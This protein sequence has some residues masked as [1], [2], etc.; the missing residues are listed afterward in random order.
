MKDYLGVEGALRD[1]GAARSPARR[2]FG[3]AMRAGA[4]LFVIS[5]AAV[6]AA[7]TAVPGPA[8]TLTSP[9]SLVSPR[10]PGAKAV[11]IDD[12][13]TSAR[14]DSAAWSADGKT[15][16]YTSDRGG[17]IN[18]WSRSVTG[19]VAHQL[20]NADMR[21]GGIAATPDGKSILFNADKG[22]RQVFDLYA[23]PMAGGDPVNL[24]ATDDVSETGAIPSPDGRFL[25][26]AQRVA[27][28]PSYDI[29]IFDMA[30]SKARQ[31][32]HEATDGIQWM[33]VAISRDSRHILAN[34]FDWSLTVGE[35]YI[36]DTKTGASTRLTPAGVY[37]R[38]GDISPDG[39][40]VSASLENKQGVRQAIVIDV[41]A[42]TTTQL[43]HSEWEETAGRF[44]PDGKSLVVTTNVDG[45]DTLALYDV[46]SRK[47][48]PLRVPAGVNSTAGYVTGLPS[49]SPD[50]RRLLFPHS[51]GSEPLD[52]WVYDLGTNEATRV[53]DLAGTFGARLP[54]TQIVHYS[55][56]DG[57]VVSALLWMPFNL[58]RD[59][60]A[61]AVVL[62]HGGPTGQVTDSFDR[63]AAALASRGYVVIAPNFRGSTG[64]GRAFL[65]ANRKDLGGGDLADV[66]AGADF[67]TRSGYVDPKRIG[68]TGGSYGGYM[69]LMA[70]SKMP[71]KWA[72]GVELFGI[73]NWRTMW[74]HGAPQNRRYQAGLIGDPATDAEVYDRVSPLTYLD[75]T[76]APLLV[77]HG[78]ND[79]L[80]PVL[81]AR[82]VV[83][84]LKRAGKT[85]D[86]HYYAD[87]GHGFAKRENQIDMVQRTIAWFDRYLARK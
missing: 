83:A 10:S 15:V 47:S 23:L 70:I 61:P 17:R 29:A 80:V 11:S 49:F 53:T 26:F 7:Q 55:S 27:T 44:S 3:G 48:R 73:V 84:T 18:I 79:P 76:A 65:E 14:S 46:A 77:L 5:W 63:T 19:G 8:R 6:A 42:H 40:L 38:A 72:A 36:I 54:R 56:G 74:E 21:Q 31:L 35:V 59:A 2:S 9:R 58:K 22:G 81:E 57:T 32:T 62:P 13:F 1:T 25:A 51:S 12:L 37:A 75:R 4:A 66:A 67:L 39:R 20:S 69:T 43:P 78:E 28:A 60:T 85:V 50:G 34:R 68:I 33:P 45:R 41:K 82:E 71:D 30:S 64:Y 87:E 24:T 86:S 16:I 52:Y